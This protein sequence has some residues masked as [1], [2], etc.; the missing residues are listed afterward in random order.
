MWGGD[1]FTKWAH[2]IGNI[3]TCLHHAKSPW[4]FLGGRENKLKCKVLLGRLMISVA[5]IKLTMYYRYSKVFYIY[6][7]LQFLVRAVAFTDLCSEY[8]DILIF[9]TCRQGPPSRIINSRVECVFDTYW[10]LMLY[11]KG[12][13][14][15]LWHFALDKIPSSVQLTILLVTVLYLLLRSN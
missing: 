3:L 4:L 2:W 5:K 14:P 8:E 1:F 6:P 7:F 15:G 9:N 11:L 12:A 13:N 10:I